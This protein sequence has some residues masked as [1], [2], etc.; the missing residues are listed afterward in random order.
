MHCRGFSLFECLMYIAVS[1][2][3]YAITCSWF[4]HIVYR[5]VQTRTNNSV[6]IALLSAIDCCTRDIHAAPANISQ[7][8][9][10]EKNYI[11]WKTDKMIV[12]YYYDGNRIIR[13]SSNK[14]KGDYKKRPYAKSQIASGVC[15]C[16]FQHDRAN[17][18]IKGIVLHMSLTK[19]NITKER[20]QYVALRNTQ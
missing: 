10:T 19:N 2:M 16:D 14:K 9:H 12:G 15:A 20:T 3:L 18:L 5:N 6:E 11:A 13:I 7:W 17:Q 1:S 4:S 8:V